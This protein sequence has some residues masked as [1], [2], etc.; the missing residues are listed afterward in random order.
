ML[1]APAGI[2]ANMASLLL[3]VIERE[4]ENKLRDMYIGGKVIHLKTIHY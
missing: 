3:V 1:E 2:S 4:E